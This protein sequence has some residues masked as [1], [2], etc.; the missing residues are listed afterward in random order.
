LVERGPHD[1]FEYEGTS[2]GLQ[3][4]ETKNKNQDKITQKTAN[5]RPIMENDHNNSKNNPV[6]YLL[7]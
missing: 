5:F 2:A 3:N 7:K 4:N 6:M 1:Y